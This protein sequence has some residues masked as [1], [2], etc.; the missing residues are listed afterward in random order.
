[1][2]NLVF[3]QITN[4]SPKEFLKI[5]DRIDIATFQ[6]AVTVVAQQLQFLTI[7][8]QIII[9][10]K[11]IKIYQTFAIIKLFVRIL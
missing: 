2:R 3:V 6:K 4:L 5:T 1:M 7:K 9:S 11:L 10:N 8:L